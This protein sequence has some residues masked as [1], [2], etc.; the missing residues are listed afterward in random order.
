MKL[1]VAIIQPTKLRAVRAALETIGV[2]RY[3]VGDAMGYARQG[4][5]AETYRGHEYHSVLLRKVVI[6]ATV[7]EDFVERTIACLRE[8]A[9]T[10]SEGHVGDGKVFVLPVEEVIQISDGSRGTGA[11]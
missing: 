5:H 9:R 10:N 6:E 8:H 4:G 3:S 7:N 2:W 11:V 1:V